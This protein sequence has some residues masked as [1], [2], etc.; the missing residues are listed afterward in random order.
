MSDTCREHVSSYHDL[1]CN[2]VDYY[3]PVLFTLDLL[4]RTP[5]NRAV[6]QIRNTT[7]VI[8]NHI[9]SVS[10][11][12]HPK[13]TESLTT[14]IECDSSTLIFFYNAFPERGANL[15]NKIEDI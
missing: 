10:D 6:R 9:S 7:I 3:F 11:T 8:D 14:T 15:S 1:I 12:V 13:A 2:N 4:P 5:S